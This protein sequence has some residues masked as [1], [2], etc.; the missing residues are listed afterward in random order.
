MKG[1]SVFVVLITI[2]IV[3]FQ[4]EEDDRIKVSEDEEVTSMGEIV[5]ITFRI[6]K[7]K[8]MRLHL[9]HMYLSFCTM[10]VGLL[11]GK[12]YLLDTLK[13]N[14]EKLSYMDL[15]NFPIGLIS[16]VFIGKYIYDKP[17]NYYHISSFIICIT[18]LICI[19]VLFY[20]F[21]ALKGP[22]FDV[23]LFGI[24]LITSLSYRVVSSARMCLANKVSNISIA[25]TQITLF[26]SLGNMMWYI[27]KIYSY[28]IVDYFELYWPNL[29]GCIIN[30]IILICM[31][32]LAKYLD[33]LP[34]EEWI[35]DEK[36]KKE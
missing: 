18:Q 24:N 2:Y 26:N 7:N 15:I 33:Q 14:Q 30:F 27:P 36:V 1:W 3:L 12:T 22:Y 29:I 16:S 6:V 5:K 11:V 31:Y 35:D 21:E 28:V 32:P 25:S 9:L 4:S 13:Y 17:S 19:N 10:S 8:N 34:K 23:C 20:N